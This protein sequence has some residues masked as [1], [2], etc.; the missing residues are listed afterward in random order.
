MELIA[1]AKGD[2]QIYLGFI[3]GN[4]NAYQQL[5]GRYYRPLCLFLSKMGLDSFL[6]EEI[7]QDIFLKV[8]DRRTDFPNLPTIRSFLFISCK[9]AALNAFDKE[10]RLKSKAAKFVDDQDW[11]ELPI[12]QQIIYS[13]TIQAIHQAIEK[14]PTQC[15]KVMQLLFI[16]GLSTQEVA[17]EMAITTSTVYNQKQ[18]GIAL[19]KDILSMEQLWL[20]LLFLDSF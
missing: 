13:E 2:D 19:L 4:R 16:D 11:V 3:A 5:F 10:K 7:V 1:E 6:V 12:T 20:L 17:E 9:N 18:R 8:W 14:L 15:R